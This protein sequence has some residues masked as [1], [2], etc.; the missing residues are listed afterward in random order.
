MEKTFSLLHLHKKQSHEFRSG[1]C[2]GQ[3]VPALLIHVL[4]KWLF[5]QLCMKNG[6]SNYEAETTCPYKYTKRC[7]LLQEWKHSL[8]EI[9]VL[10]STKTIC[11]HKWFS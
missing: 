5:N 11:Y 2:G 10:D 8:E 7:S 9:I 1:E 3:I 4:E 6:W